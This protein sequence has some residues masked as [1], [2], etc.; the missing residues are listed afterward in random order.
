MGENFIFSHFF[1]FKENI[2]KERCDTIMIDYIVDKITP[3]LQKSY[4]KRFFDWFIRKLDL[5]EKSEELEQKKNKGKHPIRPR[6]GD[7]Y[8][9]EFGQNI[10]KELSNMH[11]GI[12]VQSSSNNIA[13]HTVIVVPISSSPK[14]Y[15]THEKIIEKDIKTGRLDKFPSKAKTDQI[16]CIDKAR[17][18]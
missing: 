8:L 17:M 16:T 9:I 15:N 14:L 2:I 13:S 12:V 6:K 4:I 1:I 5:Q 7:I 10:G 3:Y 11:M 18:L